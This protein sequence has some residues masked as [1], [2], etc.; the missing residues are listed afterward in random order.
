MNLLHIIYYT[1]TT[2][3]MEVRS[4]ASLKRKLL[5]RSQQNADAPTLL[6]V[7]GH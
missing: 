6:P 7:L 1:L 4:K 5:E 3:G 2:H